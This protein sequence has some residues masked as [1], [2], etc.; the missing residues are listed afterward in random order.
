MLNR[1]KRIWELSRYDDKTLD[2]TEAVVGVKELKGEAT[3]EKQ[4]PNGAY[5]D[6]M[7]DEQ[8]ADWEREQDDVWH[9]FMNTVRN[10]GK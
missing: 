6:D 7:T 3:T 1:L 9:R 10:L 5:L 4:K 8:Y 2:L